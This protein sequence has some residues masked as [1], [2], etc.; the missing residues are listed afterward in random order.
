VFR[1]TD[2]E[3]RFD[4]FDGG[5]SVK[6]SSEDGITLATMSVGKYLLSDHD[7]PFSGPLGLTRFVVDFL[8]SPA[9]VLV[10]DSA[11]Q[12]TGRVGN[13]YIAQIPN[14]HPFFLA[15]G[16]YLLPADEALTRR[17]TGT[18]SG[19]YAFHSIAP[20]GASISIEGITTTAGQTDVLSVNADGT[21]IRFTPGA[22]KAFTL[23]LAREVAGQAREVT[24]TGAGAG[25]TTAVDVNASPDL[26]V[27]RLSN[28]DATRTVEVQ[29]GQIVKDTGA[30]ARLNRSI[31]LPTDNDLL[32]TVTDWADLNLT[33]R[34][35]PF[36]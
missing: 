14:S 10:E 22:S 21:A 5:T 3:I 36:A 25:P 1:M 12:Q 29:V 19:N 30:H 28:T 24:I 26:S 15:R 17:I 9:D 11:G 7:L 13:T 20:N 31:S 16:A 4:Y 8:L 23:N 33:V 18:A 27:V 32:V 35:L 34:T 6:F 2:G